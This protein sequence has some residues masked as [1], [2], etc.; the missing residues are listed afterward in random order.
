MFSRKWGAYF[1]NTLS[2]EHLWRTA[3]VYTS[4]ERGTEMSFTFSGSGIEMEHLTE[5]GWHAAFL[6]S[7]KPCRAWFAY[8]FFLVF[9]PE[10]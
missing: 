5:M 9:K 7:A 4:W 10:I 6:A 1:Q 3:S 2:K 8:L